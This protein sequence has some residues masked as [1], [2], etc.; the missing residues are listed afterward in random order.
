MAID[1]L[2]Y[3]KSVE[4]HGI[5]QKIAGYDDRMNF[6]MTVGCHRPMVS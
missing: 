3:G 5:F 6:I 4:V 1:E 2:P